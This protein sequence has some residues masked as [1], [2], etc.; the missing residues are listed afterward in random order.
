MRGVCGREV[1]IYRGVGTRRM[2]IKK[3]QSVD[4]K[5]GGGERNANANTVDKSKYAL[6]YYYSYAAE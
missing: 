2:L 6:I 3:I 4:D 1:L 5:A